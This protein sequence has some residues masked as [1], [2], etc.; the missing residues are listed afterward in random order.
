MNLLFCYTLE[1][2]FCGA[3]F[4]KYDYFHFNLENFQE[5]AEQFMTSLIDLFDPDQVKVK[6]LM[7]EI[8]EIIQR[9]EKGGS[10][11]DS[12]SEGSTTTGNNFIQA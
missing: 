8:E 5:I 4:G 9:N 3:D 12:D 1:L 6:S 7:L 2:S 10:E 11:D